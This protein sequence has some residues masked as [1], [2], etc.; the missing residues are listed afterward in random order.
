MWPF[1]RRP[2]DPLQRDLQRAHG[3]VH[4]RK[5]EEAAELLETLC[6]QHP[7]HFGAHVNLGAALHNLGR[8]TPAIERLERAHEL[9][10]DH[11][12][13]LLNLAAAHNALGHVDRAVETL[14][15]LADKHP[16]HRDVNYNLAIAYGKQGDLEQACTALQ[17]ELQHFPDHALARKLLDQL[18]ER[19]AEQVRVRIGRAAEQDAEAAEGDSPPDPSSPSGGNDA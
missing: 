9:D 6:D 19:L 8:F 4:R 13:P 14:E 2:R 10:P 18:A 11:A 1:R 16:E 12:T 3:L 7:D 17:Q 15:L 5:F